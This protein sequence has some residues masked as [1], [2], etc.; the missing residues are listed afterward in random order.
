MDKTEL[1]PVV[2]IGAGGQLGYD[3]V[4]ILRQK[5]W[6]VIPLTHQQLEIKDDRQVKRMLGRLKPEVVINTAAF[7]HL[8]NCETNPQEAFAVNMLGVSH[9]ASWCKDNEVVLVHFSTDYVFGGDV[10]RRRAY[11]ETDPVAPQS[12]YAV[13]KVAGEMMVQTMLKRH[14]II[15]TSGLYGAAGSAAKG[16]NFVERMIAK[17]KS[18]ETIHMVDD[19]VLSP[20]YTVN[21]A[22][23]VARLI[24]TDKFGLYHAV[25]GGQCSWY[26]FTKEIFRLLAMQV[27]VVP[28]KSNHKQAGAVRPAYSVLS[29]D[30][31]TSLGI[32][33]MRHWRENL[34]LYL[35]EKGYLA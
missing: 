19:Q 23:N 8:P 11:T 16:G 35:Q 7:H 17:A 9:L 10:K 6:S 31:L 22:E 18:G 3:L 29:T 1:R 27:K 4:R 2:V 34:K 12:L 30:K 26:E 15:R 28:V 21:L 32:N 13:S 5:R 33:T 25:S 20:T 24:K 14:F